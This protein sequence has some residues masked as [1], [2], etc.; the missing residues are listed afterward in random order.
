MLVLEN[1]SLRVTLL[2]PHADRDR[3][4][5]RYC[6]GGYIFQVEDKQLGPLLAI[7]DQLTDEQAKQYSNG[8]VW[9]DGFNVQDGQGIPDCFSGHGR[10]NPEADGTMLVLGVGVCTGKKV[11]EWAGALLCLPPPFTHGVLLFS[12]V[13][14]HH[15]SNSC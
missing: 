9:E 14:A 1:A 11:D 12:N 8:K 4:S 6:C 5:I 13:A 7:P 15:F 10:P 3:L 2:D